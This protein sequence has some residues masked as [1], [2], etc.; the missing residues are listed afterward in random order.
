VTF[1][2]RIK[3]K[4]ENRPRRDIFDRFPGTA[5]ERFV[6]GLEVVYD[7]ILVLGDEIA[8]LREKVEAL[9]VQ[10]VPFSDPP[11]TIEPGNAATDNT[12]PSN[13]GPRLVDKPCKACGEMMLQVHPA[14]QKCQK[15]KEAK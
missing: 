14:T 12:P 11:L 4:L 8:E 15:C 2:D 3:S 6:A 9:E 1:L 10:R 13:T 5:M 7:E